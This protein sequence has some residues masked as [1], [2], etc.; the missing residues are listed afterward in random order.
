MEGLLGATGDGIDSKRSGGITGVKV[1]ELITTVP[2]VYW[3]LQGTELIADGPEGLL[4]ATGDGIDSKH[5]GGIT[6]SYR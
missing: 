6:G 1:S 4:V 2:K 3:G 5:S